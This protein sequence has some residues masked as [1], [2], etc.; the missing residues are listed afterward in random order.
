[1]HFR[2]AAE[3]EMSKALVPEHSQCRASE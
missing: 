2:E 1:M 3:V